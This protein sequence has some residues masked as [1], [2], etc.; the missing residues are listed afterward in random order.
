MIAVCGLC[1]HPPTQETMPACCNALRRSGT[2][3]ASGWM[4]NLWLNHSC[5]EGLMLRRISLTGG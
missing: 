2:G 5:A 4:R 1:C 3:F